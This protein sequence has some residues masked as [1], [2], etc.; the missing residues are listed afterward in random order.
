VPPNARPALQSLLDEIHDLERRIA[1]VERQLE[2]IRRQN[3]I[4]DSLHL[5]AC[6]RSPC[7]LI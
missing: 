4:I 1:A 7:W 5:R 6:G 3:P 2:A